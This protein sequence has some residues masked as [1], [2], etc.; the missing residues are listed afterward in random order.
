M[1]L[2]LAS[3]ILGVSHKGGIKGEASLQR[4]GIQCKNQKQFH[5]MAHC[6]LHKEAIHQ[7]Q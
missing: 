5:S 3:H 6:T 1:K 2:K 4:G 7:T